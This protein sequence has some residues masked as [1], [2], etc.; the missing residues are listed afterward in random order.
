MRL[1]KIQNNFKDVLLGDK[2]PN[3]T[4]QDFQALFKVGDIPLEQ[5]FS[6]YQNNVL[7]SLT[8]VIT[9]NY[10]LIS[11]LTGEEFARSMARQYIKS[12]P[13]QQ[14]NMNMFG[15]QYPTFIQSFEPA[16]S[17][18][19]L[20]DIARLE[21]SIN[22][23]TYA[24]DD[25]PLNPE[26]LSEASDDIHFDL[27]HSVFL[28]ESDYPLTAIRDYCL[29]EDE[30]APDLDIGSQGKEYIL[31]HRPYL[32]AEVVLLDEQTYLFLRYLEKK[33]TLEKIFETLLAKQPNTQPETLLYKLF[34]LN[35]FAAKETLE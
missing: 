17:L 28:I 33:W 4:D 30:N 31:V 2:N 11:I 16:R 22:L 20:A 12:H 3:E 25:Q 19:Y 5:R 15:D 27:R 32:K 34:E 8:D 1:N 10:P 24:R 6:V 29:S 35:V 26:T 21:W 7:K 13:P 9:A 23:A 14:A 18:A